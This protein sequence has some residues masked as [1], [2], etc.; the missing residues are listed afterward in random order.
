MGK[1]VIS[2][3][4]GDLGG[5]VTKALL[6]EQPDRELT[7]VTRSPA[8][9]EHLASPTVAVKFGDYQDRASLDAAYAGGDTLLLI[10]GLNL[11][12]R[13]EEHRNA[14]E[15]AKAAGIRHIVYTS[16][17]GVHP[18][19][20]ALS[21]KDHYA[22]EQDL[23][24]SGLGVVILR[25][26]LYAEIVTNYVIHAALPFGEFNMAAGNGKL[27]PVSKLDVV[28]CT[29]QC[30]SNAEKHAGAVYE[31]TGPERF[32]LHE[33]AAMAADVHGQ[34][35]KY[36]PVTPDERLAFF[37]SIGYPRTYDPDMPMSAD[38]HMWASDELVS[39]DCALAQGYQAMLTD[40][41]RMIM[42]QEPESLRSVFER[43]KGLR[44]D[45]C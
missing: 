1:I 37:D 31:V 34:P 24:A 28:R 12:R 27:S 33:I 5:R 26:S 20:P 29:A 44:Y 30:L 7:L 6:N 42:G 40:H 18:N 17:L 21:A 11:G 32:T 19:N 41:A 4:S 3:A 39:A 14:I 9:L 45:Q 25:N 13:V 43:C 35:M 15:A 22:T 10:S 2:G 16:V 36:L 23:R 38:G 8:K